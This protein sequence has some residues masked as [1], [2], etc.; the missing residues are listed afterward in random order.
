MSETQ[1]T[2]FWYRHAYLTS[3]IVSDDPNKVPGRYRY[4]NRPKSESFAAFD[5]LEGRRTMVFGAGNDERAGGHSRGVVAQFIRDD[6]AA[7][8]CKFWWKQSSSFEDRGSGSENTDLD[9]Q[10]VLRSE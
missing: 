7:A 8:E 3:F 2:I 4:P 10:S 1:D 5:P 6:F 9:L